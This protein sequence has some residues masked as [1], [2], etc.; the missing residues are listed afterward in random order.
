MGSTSRFLTPEEAVAAASGMDVQVREFRRLGG[1]WTLDRVW[2]RLGI[3]AA[4]RTAATGRRFDGPAVERV[5]FALVARRS[6]GR[7]RTSV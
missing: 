4:I 3:G 5:V 7:V 2:E 1:T 6:T